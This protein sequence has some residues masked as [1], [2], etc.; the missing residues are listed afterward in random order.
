M[1][2]LVKCCDK[3]AQKL[4]S[5]YEQHNY[6]LTFIVR[7]TMFIVVQFHIEWWANWEEV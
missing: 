3:K 5:L 7:L 4:V 2:C 1:F 6:N